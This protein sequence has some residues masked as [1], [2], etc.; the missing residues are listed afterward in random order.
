M[1]YTNGTQTQLEDDTQ[2]A[3]GEEFAQPTLRKNSAQAASSEDQSYAKQQLLVKPS[4]SK[5]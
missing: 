4:E 3:Q 5:L 2:P 1:S